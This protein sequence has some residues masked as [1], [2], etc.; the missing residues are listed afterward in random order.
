MTIQHTRE[1]SVEMRSCRCSWTY[2]ENKSGAK[3][4]PLG[5]VLKN[6]ALLEGGGVFFLNNHV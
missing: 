3:M 1:S 4:A 6:G 2:T 5:A